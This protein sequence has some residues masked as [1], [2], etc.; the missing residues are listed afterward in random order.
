[1]HGLTSLAISFQTGIHYI[2]GPCSMRRSDLSMVMMSQIEHFLVDLQTIRFPE[3]RLFAA[4]GDKLFRLGV[5]ILRAHEGDA[6]NPL[7][8]QQGIENSIMNLI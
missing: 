8:Q 4:Y 3:E 2:Y 6:L 5:C 1:M 7:S